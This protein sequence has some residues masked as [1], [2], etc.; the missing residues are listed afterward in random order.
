MPVKLG[1]EIALRVTSDVNDELHVHGY[2]LKTD[3]KPAGPS[4]L[5][6]TAELPGVYEVE[7]EEAGVRLVELQVQ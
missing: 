1:E 6:F 4:T 7:L 3:V 5:R 2:D